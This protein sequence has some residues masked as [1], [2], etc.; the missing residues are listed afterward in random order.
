MGTKF[1]SYVRVSTEGQGRSGLGLDA[2]RAAI[3][4]HVESTGGVLVAEYR[5]VESGKRDDRPRLKEALRRCREEDCILLIAKLDR[6]ARKL[7]VVAELMDSGVEFVAL[8]MPTKNRFMLHVYAAMAEEEGRLISERTRAGLAERRKR[9]LPLGRAARTGPMT[10][11][12]EA[13]WLEVLRR[14]KEQ[15]V[16]VSQDFAD[17]MRPVILPLRDRK[18]SLQQI[19]DWLNGHGYKSPRGSV[20]TRHTV[21]IVLMQLGRDTSQ[22]WKAEH[23]KQVK[24]LGKELEESGASL[25][26]I[27]RVFREHGVT[28]VKGKHYDREGVRSMMLIGANDGRRTESRGFVLSEDQKRKIRETVEELRRIRP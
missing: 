17:L 21:R 16:Q 8:D 12:M 20:F 22:T 18:M 9:G 5:E 15:M 25:S 6:L 11:R 13:A 2:Q 23:F 19:A 28:N 1:V 14:R 7:R 26:T 24:S 27:A 4:R 3:G 10:A